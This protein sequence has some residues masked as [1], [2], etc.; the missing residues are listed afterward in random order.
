LA[1]YLS[2]LGHDVQI[3][4][5]DK[6]E[7]IFVCVP[8]YAVVPAL[9]KE[10][11]TNQK[12]IICS[13]GFASGEKL[14]SEAL[15]EKFKN[16]IFF[17]YGPT[18]AEELEKGELSAMVLAGGEGKEELKKQIESETLH[19]ELSDDIIG[20]QVGAALKNV[21]TIF[22]GIIK[23]AGCGQNTQAYIFTKG[24]QEI[25]K[26][27]VALGAE[28]DTF[29]GLTCIG[30]LTLHSRNRYLGIELG[31]GRNLDDI[32]LEMHYIPEG[33]NALRNA[34][35]MTKKL[36]IDAPIINLLYSIIFENYS[37]QDAIKEIRKF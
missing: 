21:V 36:G 23:G 15:E 16:E 26:I 19:I 35:I 25:Q 8:S 1:S 33:I 7:V 27:G 11:I 6:S 9:L 24:V 37:I 18:L 13:K 29:F 31:K 4:E 28:P 30:D 12:I 14:L 32:L 2:N 10:K 5:A 34:K 17:L 3:D 20:A 22:V